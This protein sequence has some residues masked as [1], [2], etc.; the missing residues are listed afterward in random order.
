LEGQGEVRDG[1]VLSEAAKIEE[2]YV[3]STE[4]RSPSQ[5]VSDRIWQV[6]V[7][8]FALAFLLSLGAFIV[9]VFVGPKDIQL[10]LTIVT[11]VAGILA[12]FISGRNS[13]PR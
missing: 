7:G 10:L 13:T 4:L 11:T 5:K 8:T 12:G 6:I 3:V 2:R 9:A 1:D